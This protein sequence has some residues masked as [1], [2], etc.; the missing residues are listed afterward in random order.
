MNKC[1]KKVALTLTYSPRKFYSCCL[2]RSVTFETSNQVTVESDICSTE[3]VT[4][5]TKVLSRHL[6]YGLFP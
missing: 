3:L 1:L 4:S 5:L 6:C 2:W